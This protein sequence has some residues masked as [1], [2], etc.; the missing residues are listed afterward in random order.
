MLAEAG[1]GAR[2]YDGDCYFMELMVWKM[3]VIIM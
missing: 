2:G 3:V 1:P